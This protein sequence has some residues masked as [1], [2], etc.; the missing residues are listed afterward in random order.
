MNAKGGTYSKRPSNVV[1]ATID[2]KTGQLVTPSTKKKRTEYFTKGTQPKKA[3]ISEVS[4]T[5]CSESGYLATPDCPDTYV[6]TGYATEPPVDEEGN[7]LPHYYCNLH[8][9]DAETYPPDPDVPFT[10]IKPD[11]GTDPTPGDDDIIDD[12]DD[13]NYNPTPSE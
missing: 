5:L 13:P 7:E 9:P 3:A 4:V 10:P 8:N 11:P 1:T 12:P 2:T 6:K